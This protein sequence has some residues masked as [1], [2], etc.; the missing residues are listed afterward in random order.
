MSYYGAI[1]KA[2][3]DA[4]Q[5]S[6]QFAIDRY[7]SDRDYDLKYREFLM[8]QINELNTQ[9]ID[10]QKLISDLG[11]A[12]PKTD[13]G[14]FRADITTVVGSKGVGYNQLAIEKEIR[15][16]Y[17]MRQSAVNANSE[18][19][20]SAFSF[21]EEW[22]AEA[23]DM[24]MG[25]IGQTISNN[26][27]LFAAEPFHLADRLALALKSPT[28]PISQGTYEQKIKM[29]E[30]VRGFLVRGLGANAPAEHKGKVDHIVSQTMTLL[31]PSLG[32]NPSDMKMLIEK[33]YG[34]LE[35]RYLIDKGVGNFNQI[36]DLNDQIEHLRGLKP[37]SGFQ[38][39]TKSQALGREARDIVARRNKPEFKAVVNALANDG[40]ITKD[41]EAA[42]AAN[43]PELAKELGSLQDV[44]NAFLD[45]VFLDRLERSRAMSGLQQDTIA[46]RDELMGQYD[47][48]GVQAPLTYEGV[49]QQAAPIY[50]QMAASQV[51]VP[52]VNSTSQA[53]MR[54]L[55][56]IVKSKDA[57]P[58]S[59]E[60]QRQA[61]MI[62]K[63]YPVGMYAQGI[64]ELMAQMGGGIL[65][66]AGGT[67]V[68][69][70][71]KSALLQEVLRQQL[72]GTP[73]GYGKE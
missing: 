19:L 24:T 59:A 51:N 35:A 38:T 45:D 25:Q 34:E 28:L 6:M 17:S 2:K 52:T 46:R 66:Q 71:T 58:A 69:P 64:D 16:T 41:E 3:Q 8:N 63:S 14:Q 65:P 48:L 67:A 70:V 21:V 29:A 44:R 18:A 43:N 12:D 56:G 1:L 27:G 53:I 40:S 61:E 37:D 10:Q 31:A 5:Q 60:L 13:P 72:A 26:S 47:Q 50:E 15:E 49:R 9:I 55:S 7:A 36:E 22:N 23:R 30:D 54:G 68:A 20:K 42:W 39:T 11:L 4:L 57:P 62:R 33:Q 32:V 73:S